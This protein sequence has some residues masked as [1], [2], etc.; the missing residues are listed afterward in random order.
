MNIFDA[1][2]QRRAIKQYD[3]DHVMSDDE[4][5]QLME[6]TLQAPT[7]FNIQH[8][9]FVLVQ[10]KDKRKELREAAWDQAQV[11]DASLIFVLTADVKAWEKNPQRYWEHA[12]QQTQDIL[13]PMIKQFYEGREWIQRDE[14]MR[15][16]GLAAQTMMLTAKGMG[17]DSCPMIGFDQDHVAKII[18]LPE[19]H[20]ICMMVAVGKGTKEAWDK[21]GQLPLENV[22][23]KNSF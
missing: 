11:T 12:P 14:V 10:D 23:I 7:S 13:V 3:P 20:V 22:L 4:I 16:A 19:D 5:T 6:L 21:P 8:W 17:Y 9:R 15:S 2:K 18:N 1:I